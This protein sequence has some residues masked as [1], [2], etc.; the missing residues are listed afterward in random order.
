MNRT[1][2]YAHYEDKYAFLEEITE[3]AFHEM[4]PE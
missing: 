3:Q 1:T 2:L 4:I